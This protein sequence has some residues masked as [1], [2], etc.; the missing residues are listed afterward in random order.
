MTVLRIRGSIAE[1]PEQCEWAL[2]EENHAPVL[3]NGRLADLPRH[4]RRVQFVIP[5]CQVLI[6]RAHLPRG[7]RRRASSVLAFAVE[8]ATLG[9]PDTQQV[10]WLGTLDGADVLAVVDRQCLQSWLDALDAAGISGCEVHCETLLLPW[11]PGDW[12]LVWN[13]RE[14]IV[15]TGQ[16]EGAATDCGSQQSP[17][18]YLRLALDAASRNGIRPA[19]IAIYAT[20]PDA[21]PDIEAWQRELGMPLRSAGLW[22]WH[23]AASQPGVCLMQKRRR[24]RALGSIIPRLR[25]ALWI[26]ACAL[27]IHLAALGTDLALLAGESQS[28]QRRMETR[29]RAVFPDA[30]AIAD[31]ALQMRRKLTEARHNAGIPDSSD[32]LPLMGKVATVTRELPAGSLRTATYENGRLTLQF[33]TID[34]TTLRRLVARL[35]QTG[36]QVDASST[37]TKPGSGTLTV[38]VS[39]L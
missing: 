4:V 29:F 23:S 27:A 15:R 11:T 20:K 16:M 7:A 18:L 3:G 28:L 12:S 14:G 13:G 10:S 30:V 6:T 38:I 2:I 36:L 8:E 19:S 25:P 32:F 35:E 17:P 9:E 21:A 1:S 5:A 24:W 37:A 22:N 39:A 26:A 33:T 34:D 31:P